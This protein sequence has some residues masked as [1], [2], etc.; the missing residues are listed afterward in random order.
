MKVKSSE[1][2]RKALALIESGEQMYACAAIQDVE[3]DL[4][5]A[6]NG[7]DV[8]TNAAKIFSVYKPAEIPENM[9]T[10]QGWWP[11]GSTLRI[12]ALKKAIGMA[13]KRGD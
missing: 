1:V 6:N 12:D 3:T 7:K 9:K 8:K 5:F 2:L 11:K 4:R 10:S 13:L